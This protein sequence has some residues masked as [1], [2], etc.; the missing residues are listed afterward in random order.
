MEAVFAQAG[1]L[2]KI[3]DGVKDLLT[4]V[5]VDY[6]EKGIHLQSMDSSHVSLVALNISG[7]ALDHYKC[8]ANQSLGISIASLVKIL[9]CAGNDDTLTLKFASKEDSLQFMFEDSK[10]TRISHFRLKLID[11]DSEHLGIPD[12]EYDVCIRMPSG[13]FQRII[14]ELQSLGDTVTISASKE[15]AIFAV[16][17]DIGTGKIVCKDTTSIT[18][19]KDSKEDEEVAIKI[20]KDTQL[21]FALRYLASFTKATSLSPSVT[22][23]MAKDVPLVVEYLIQTPDD[24]EL[25]HIRFYLAPKI[26]EEGDLRAGNGAADASGTDISMKKED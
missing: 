6:D 10:Q 7:K 5:N 2:K 20:K 18:M 14:K 16:S 9:K 23:K 8:E 21:T 24:N 4:D 19:D 22:L 26:E 15:G 17:G 3:F 11:I 12:T 1:V 13:E 25:G